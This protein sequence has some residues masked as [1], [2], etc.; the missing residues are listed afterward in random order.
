[1]IPFDFEYYRPKKI[2]E[3]IQLFNRLKSSGREPIYY[4]GGT[5]II[6]MARVHNIYIWMQL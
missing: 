2:K 5:E 1:M 6:S 4:G 3:A